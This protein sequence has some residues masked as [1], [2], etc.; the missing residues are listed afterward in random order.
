MKTYKCEVC[1][2]VVAKIVDSGVPVMCCGKPMVETDAYA[3]DEDAKK[4]YGIDL[5]PLKDLKDMDAVIIGVA[6]DKY[7]ELTKEDIDGI[8]TDCDNSEKV[9]I[10][11]KGILDRKQYE[12]DGY[13][14]WRL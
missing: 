5:I 13:C 9:L 11:V 10:D 14:Y 6:H 7:F 2:N 4:E 8:F 3:E 12:A 1:G